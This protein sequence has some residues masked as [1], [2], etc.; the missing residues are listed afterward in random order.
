MAFGSGSSLASDC[1][2]MRRKG[3]PSSVQLLKVGKATLLLHQ[4]S[5]SKPTAHS[6]SAATT[7]ISRSRRLF[8]LVQGIGGGDPALGSLPPHFKKACQG[9]PDG[10]PRDPPL[11]ETLLEAHLCGHLKRPEATVPTKLPR[12]AVEQLP[13]RLGAL[14]IKGGPGSFGT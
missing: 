2:W 6:G 9:G 13:H 10:L 4:H 1:C 11:C 3:F 8:S 7:S 14:R 5:S 12:R